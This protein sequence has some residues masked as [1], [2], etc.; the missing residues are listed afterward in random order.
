MASDHADVDL[1]G[2]TREQIDAIERL[3]GGSWKVSAVNSVADTADGG[4][5][6][7][8]VLCSGDMCTM[9]TFVVAADGSVKKEGGG[10]F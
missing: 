4:K 7:A 10:M 6:I 8:A 3:E 9:K 5:K 2:A 1:N